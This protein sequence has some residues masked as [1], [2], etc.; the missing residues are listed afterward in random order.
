MA[1]N[2]VESPMTPPATSPRDY[3]GGPG[4]YDGEKNYPPRTPTPNGPPEKV[5]DEDITRYGDLGEQTVGAV[6]GFPEIRDYPSTPNG[7]D[8]PGRSR[9]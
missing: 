1:N 4:C 6:P 7:T 9:Y 8:R 2:F 3:K 5:R